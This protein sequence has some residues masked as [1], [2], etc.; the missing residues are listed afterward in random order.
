[1][2]TKGDKILI[3][4]ILLAALLIFTGFQVYG[5]ADGKTYVLIEADG[6]IYQKVSLGEDGPNLKLTV[7]TAH[8]ENIVEINGNKVRMLYADCPDED[9]VRQ[10]FISRSGQMIVCL[11]NRIVIKIESDKSAKDDVDAVS[12]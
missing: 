12:F 9:C 11:P 2:I 1:M 8:G 3:V 10:G 6:R 7:P 5:F 4:S